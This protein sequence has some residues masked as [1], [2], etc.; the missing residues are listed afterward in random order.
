TVK[1]NKDKFNSNTWA[2]VPESDSAP[3][4]PC[5]KDRTNVT[6]PSKPK[7]GRGAGR[8]GQERWDAIVLTEMHWTGTQE[9]IGNGCKIINPGGEGKHAAGVAPVLSTLA[10]KCMLGHRPTMTHSVTIIQVYLPTAEAEE[11]VINSFYTDLQN[12]VSREHKNDILI[13]M[14]MDYRV[15]G[16]YGFGQRNRERNGCMTSAMQIICIHTTQNSSRP[17]HQDVGRGSDH[18]LV[19]ANIQLKLRRGM[20][21]KTK[22]KANHKQLINPVVQREYK[23]TT[24]KKDEGNH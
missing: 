16:T 10:Q 8:N 24:G 2:K 11:D 9:L 14:G 23:R 5:P 1:P 7:G 18:Q 20:P 6:S 19:M 4:P 15:M 21:G 3:V 13:A 22:Q 17:N 12:K